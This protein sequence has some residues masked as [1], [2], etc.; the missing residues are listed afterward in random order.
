MTSFPIVVT[1]FLIIP[2]WPTCLQNDS[3]EHVLLMI[4]VVIARIIHQKIFFVMLLPLV[5]PFLQG[6]KQQ[7]IYFAKCFCST[8]LIAQKAYFAKSFCNEFGRD[9]SDYMFQRLYL[10]YYLRPKIFYK[11]LVVQ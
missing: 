3:L 9:G 4:F 6:N 1:N 11:E 7:G 5:C 10:P 2:S 8:E